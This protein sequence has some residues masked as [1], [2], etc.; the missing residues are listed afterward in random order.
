[1]DKS[2]T[3][4]SYQDLKWVLPEWDYF[5]DEL[6]SIFRLTD[7]EKEQLNN[8][9]T[10]KI[11]ATIPFVANCVE[12]ERTAIS[13]LCVYFAELKGVQKYFAHLPYDDFNVYNRLACISTFKGGDEKIIQ[14][15]LDLLVLIMIEGYQKSKAKDA[16]QNIYN[17]F[18][19]GIWNYKKLK[20]EVTAKI[21]K[22]YVP[23]LDSLFYSMPEATWR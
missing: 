12:P 6:S 23:D 3:V 8:S 14:H 18:V 21:N 15:G 19:S 1:M 17:P 11:I 5:V 4:Y 22:M 2:N 20:K 16:L 10:A 13:H 7:E 9:Y